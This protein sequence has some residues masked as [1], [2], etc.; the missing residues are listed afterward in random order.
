MKNRLVLLGILALGFLFLAACYVEL[1]DQTNRTYEESVRPVIFTGQTATVSFENLNRNDIFLVKVNTSGVVVDAANTGRVH[2]IYSSSEDIDTPEELSMESLPQLGHHPIARKFNANPPPIAAEALNKPRSASF[3]RFT[4][5]SVGDTRQFY[6]EAYLGS[7]NW[8][9]RQAT[10]RAVGRHANIWVMDENFSPTINFG[11]RITAAQARSLAERFDR[12]HPLAT[13][14][15]G[16][17]FGGQPGCP[18]WPGG[19]DGDPR[20]QILIYDIVDASGQTAAAGYFWAKDFFTQEELDAASWNVRT[21]LAEIFYLDASIL[22]TNPDFMYSTLIHELQ[23]MINFNVKFLRHGVASPVWYD[24]MLSMMTEDIIAPLI[25]IPATSRDHIIQHRTPRFLR[26][27][28]DAGITEWRTDSL[29]NTLNSY[30]NG[31]AFGAFLLRNFGGANLLRR[32]LANNTVGIASIS[33]A[34]IEVSQGMTFER[35][36][37]RYGEALIFSGRAVPEG[38]LT[39]DRTTT[40][41]V[42]GVTYTAFAFNIWNMFRM[43]GGMGPYFFDLAPRAMRPHS[44]SIHSTSAWRNRSGDFS[45]TLERPDNA[46]VAF[47]LMVR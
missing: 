45:I 3:P 26:H 33:L 47:Y 37:A 4:A 10:L 28:A 18:G 20:I 25:G 23:H 34:L 36:L 21:N 8:L 22:N 31:F 11:N 29:S 44:I 17:E 43:G 24:E 30:A 41:T 39:L 42:N 27:Y 16:F 13:N 32:I 40:S 38:V 9:S 5:P 46:N 12:I 14:I 2:G 1:V 35:A 6:V 7:S 19:V 15:L